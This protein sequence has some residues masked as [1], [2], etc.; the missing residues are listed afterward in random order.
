MCTRRGDRVTAF[1]SV[2]R[3]MAYIPIL[4]ERHVYAVGLD[5]F[6]H[7]WPPPD[8]AALFP[9]LHNRVALVPVRQPWLLPDIPAA[10]PALHRW[11]AACP[12]L[13][14]WAVESRDPVLHLPETSAGF[15]G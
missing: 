12:S 5:P 1:V 7:P 10:V 3:V 2:C 14:P 11:A 15:K 6:R 4:P 8:P 13:H 9:W